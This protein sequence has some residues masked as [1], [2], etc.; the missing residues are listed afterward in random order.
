MI[1]DYSIPHIPPQAS[2]PRMGEVH[3]IIQ[4]L[5]QNDPV[6]SPLTV[7]LELRCQTHT[8][9]MHYLHRI[10][11]AEN[12]TASRS[13]HTMGITQ[14]VH[15]ARRVLPSTDQRMIGLWRSNF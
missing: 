2:P 4:M 7:R 15:L 6:F 10:A 5:A 11:P 1:L 3:L 8:R 12:R 14:G 13:R 9:T